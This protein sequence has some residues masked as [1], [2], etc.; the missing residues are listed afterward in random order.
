MATV[1]SAVQSVG[2][3]FA[4]SHQVFLCTNVFSVEE[5][6]L[7]LIPSQGCGRRNLPMSLL[8]CVHSSKSIR[9]PTALPLPNVPCLLEISLQM[10]ARWKQ[11]TC[12]SDWLQTH[13]HS[14]ARR[15]HVKLSQAAKASLW[16]CTTQG[17]MVKSART[18]AHTN[19][20]INIQNYK[21][22]KHWPSPWNL[23]CKWSCTRTLLMIQ[24]Q[25][26]LSFSRLWTLSAS[27]TL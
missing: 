27:W 15:L 25:T 3:E 13:L 12:H 11:N 5:G 1:I 22:E 21:P 18:H 20:Y 8:H 2:S 24:F 6:V 19:T 9:Q 14:Q 10:K 23:S 16:T 4:P 17:T 7:T 26:Q